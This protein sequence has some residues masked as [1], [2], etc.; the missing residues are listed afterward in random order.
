MRAIIDPVEPDQI[1]KAFKD[2]IAHLQQG[3]ILD[4]LKSI[5]GSVLVAADGTGL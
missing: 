2:I 1:H 4:A 5:D 3:K